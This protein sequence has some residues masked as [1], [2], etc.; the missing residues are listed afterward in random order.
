M[1]VISP[2]PLRLDIEETLKKGANIYKLQDEQKRYT[3]EEQNALKK[4]SFRD[5]IRLGLP[6][7]FGRYPQNADGSSEPVE[8]LVLEHDDETALLISRYILDVASYYQN[9]ED[10]SALV[11][12]SLRKK[13]KG[14]MEKCRLKDILKIL[15]VKGKDTEIYSV[16]TVEEMQRNFESILQISTEPTDYVKSEY[17]DDYECEEAIN[18]YWWLKDVSDD[19]KY[20]AYVNMLGYVNL[21]DAMSV[22]RI[23]GV[24]PAIRIDLSKFEEDLEF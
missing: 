19:G 17:H 2:E 9:T 5:R 21:P 23:L 13:L 12:D 20:A 10:D 7:L 1:R 15:P 6:I 3:V 14:I 22:N 4:I 8:W 24:R 16:L 18:G 11:Y